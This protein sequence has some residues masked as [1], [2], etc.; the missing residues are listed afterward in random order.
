VVN[1]AVRT[2]HDVLLFSFFLLNLIVIYK[3]TNNPE[4]GRIIT[5]QKIVKIVGEKIFFFK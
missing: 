4:F 2:G 1:P 5:Y 3:G